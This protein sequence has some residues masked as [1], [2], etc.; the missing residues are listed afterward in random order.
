MA[1]I[2]SF[3]LDGRPLL[4]TAGHDWTVRIWDP[5]IPGQGRARD[6]H[7]SLLTGITAFVLDDRSLAATTSLDGSI[8]I[9]DT[10]TGRHLRTLEDGTRLRSIAT[11]SQGGRV[12]LAGVSEH[13]AR[14]HVWDIATGRL[15][16]RLNSH[17]PH[18]ITAFTLGGHVRLATVGSDSTIRVWDPFTG[19][20]R[21]IHRYSRIGY[22][23]SEKLRS[24]MEHVA[25]AS[26]ITAFALDD[27]VI[28]A[29]LSHD[30]I[31]LWD[32][33]TGREQRVLSG[34]ADQR[35]KLAA[36]TVD[37]RVLIAAGGGPSVRV[38]DAAT[39]QHLHTL[40]GHTSVVYRVERFCV[41]DRVLLASASH[42]RTVRVWDAV[43]NDCVLTIPVHS[44]AL[45]CVWTGEHLVVALSMGI[46]AIRLN[47]DALRPG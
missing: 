42:D 33:V 43:T 16:Q 20:H 15:H 37:G 5:A 44:P 21:T 10:A 17:W 23:L 18:C 13:D 46:I 36:F 4:A 2:V 8:R 28:L 39:G 3:V 9:W 19:G 12:L 26:D 38:W 34:R 47:I 7:L 24:R 35:T 32:A 29:T 1:D 31:R 41:G 22:I 6:D 25:R 27:R 30:H 40:E 14:I 45:Q 11:F